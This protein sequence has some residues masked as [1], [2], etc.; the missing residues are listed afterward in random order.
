MFGLRATVRAGGAAVR[1]AVQRPPA[2]VTRRAGSN[3][4]RHGE[5]AKSIGGAGKQLADEAVGA[6]SWMLL[7]CPILAFGLGVWQVKRKE[8]KEA[9]IEALNAR[10]DAAP[11]PLPTNP[12][13]VKELDYRKVSVTGEYDH[14]AEITLG[15]RTMLRE[16]FDGNAGDPGVHVITPFVRDDTGERILVN[17]G[18]APQPKTRP[19]TRPEGQ[20]KGKITVDAIVFNS[21]PDKANGFIPDNEP[22]KGRWFWVDIAAMAEALHTQPIMIEVAKGGTPDSGLPVAGQSQI[23]IRNEHM[24]YIITWFSLSACT[25]AMWVVR[26]RPD[27]YLRRIR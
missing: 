7:G 27:K 20:V 25:L 3:A 15:P 11:I 19:E 17:R 13:T 26:V 10:L 21:K 8:G 16:A 9:L 1:R 18:W 22:E 12:E 6:G 4:S 5:F 14:D 24:Q 2:V 23:T